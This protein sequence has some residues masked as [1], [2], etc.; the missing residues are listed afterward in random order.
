MA[1]LS[2]EV[3]KLIKQYQENLKAQKLPKGVSVIHVDKIASK[4]AALYERI[5]QVIDWKEEHLVRRAAIERILKRALL[6]E[7]SGSSVAANLKPEEIAE[8][9]V[10]ELIRG[11]HLPNDRIPRSRLTRVEPALARYIYI[12]ES[13]PGKDTFSESK[14]KIDLY[15]WLLSIAACEI[16]DILSPSVKEKA[17]IECMTN[18]MAQAISVHSDFALVD[19]Q[20]WV[21]TYIAVHRTL[22]HLD[23]PIITYNLLCHHYPGWTSP[24]PPDFEKIANQIFDIA[25]NI[26]QELN[27]SLAG[28][29]SAICEQYD[30]VYLLLGDALELLAEKPERIPARF[31]DPSR[32]ENF[33]DITYR[34]RLKTLKARLFRM[35][36]YSTLSI[37]VGSALSLFII[38]VP[39]AKLIYGKFSPLAMA[40][41][42]LFP[43]VLMFLLVGLVRPPST[44]NL[45]KVI[46]HAKKVVYQEERNVYEIRA[47]RTR[48][49]LMGFFMKLIFSLFI[50]FSLGLIILIFYLAQIPITSILVDTVNIAVIVGAALWIRE[51]AKELAVGTEGH[52]FLTLVFDS[53]TI[54]LAKFGSWV[55]AKWRKFTS[56]SIIFTALVDMPFLTFIDFIENWNQFLKEQK[57]KIR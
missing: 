13:H 30:T 21:Q 5:R 8:S 27:H 1:E 19:K 56:A 2:P 37:F 36:V 9:L 29:F 17:L 33:M 57:R 41:D 23:S 28:H 26:E 51:R 3:Q 10:T 49:T 39:L 54:P 6:S 43:T 35:A 12:L 53:L 24:S 52:G 45:H 47:Y 55:S 11:G 16:E 15:H 22:F 46:A 44:K 40:I 14:K 50:V 48:K 38:E 7:I 20:K 4:V 25:K 18:I 34:R 32:L 31:A 42:I